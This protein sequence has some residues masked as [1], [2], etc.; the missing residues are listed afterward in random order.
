MEHCNRFNARRGRALSFA[1]ALIVLVPVRAEPF[2]VPFEQALVVARSRAPLL[3]A[4][5]A[6]IAA[7][8]GD[9]LRADALP[10]PKLKAGIANWPITGSTAFAF[11]A[12]EMT[13]KQIGVMQEFPARA[14]RDARRALAERNVEQAGAARTAEML[15]VQR[16][17]AQ[18]W[19]ALRAAEREAASLREMKEPTDA[20]IRAAEARLAAG[21]TTASDALAVRSARYEL[22]DR[23]DTADAAVEAARA[24]LGR[25]LAVEPRDLRTTGPSPDVTALRQTETDLLA[26]I[27]RHGALRTWAS[28]EAVA[29]AEVDA[30]LAEKK[31]DWSVEASYGQR[32][33]APDGM[34]RDDMLM[35]EFTVSLPLFAKHRQDPAISARLAELDAI[36][37]EREDARR[38]QVEFVRRSVAEWSS[39]K[40]QVERGEQEA[41]PLARDRVRVALAGYA[42]GG[43]LDAWIDARQAEIERRIELARRFGE[44]GRI[45]AELSYLVDVEDAR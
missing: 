42:S 30:A 20:A 40:R 4:R 27:D 33:D 24:A 10:D 28:R 43:D 15:V 6:R 18:A 38:A 17:A 8:R 34:S 16:S 2:D 23:I 21:S 36:I 31:S 3:D 12:D 14:K 44:L 45:W 29:G 25:L 32:D 35:V 7:A 41:L 19:I 11:H 26:T 5:D 37:A 39:L 22:D 13:M 9:A 1:V